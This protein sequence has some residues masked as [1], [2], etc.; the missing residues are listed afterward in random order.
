MDLER[1]RGALLQACVMY[2]RSIHATQVTEPKQPWEIT[3]QS[4]HQS[5]IPSSAAHDHR[6]RRRRLTMSRDL[7]WLLIRVRHLARSRRD[8]HSHNPLE[9]QLQRCEAT[10]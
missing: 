2:H 1:L 3:V 7:E 9:T 5:T 4:L 6:Q 8:Y 10:P